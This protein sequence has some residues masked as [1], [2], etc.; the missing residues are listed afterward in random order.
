MSERTFVPACVSVA[1]AADGRGTVSAL[2]R[3]KISALL[4]VTAPVAQRPRRAAVAHLQRPA[5]DRRAAAVRVGP[6]RTI[7]PAPLCVTCPTPLI[8]LPTVTASLRL[9]T[10]AL[11]LTTAPVPSVPVVPPAPPAASRPLTVV[12]PL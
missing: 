5:A 6:V 3:L 8:R 9:K 7:V 4:F 12:A 2:L 11:L 10:T 1:R